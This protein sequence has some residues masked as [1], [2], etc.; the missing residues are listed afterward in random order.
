[1]S[2]FMYEFKMLPVYLTRTP[3]TPPSWSPYTPLPIWLHTHFHGFFFPIK[4]K[5]RTS[6]SGQPVSEVLWNVTQTPWEHRKGR[7]PASVPSLVF[8]GSFIFIELKY[9]DAF[10]FPEILT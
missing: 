4:Q 10:L 9:T 6:S 3:V 7:F 8:G 2:F 1:M 5:P